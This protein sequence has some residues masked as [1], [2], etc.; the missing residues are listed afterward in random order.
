MVSI[1]DYVLSGG[2]LAALVIIDAVMRLLPGVLGNA[3]SVRHES[4]TGG[5]LEH[6]H[7]TRPA[8]WRGMAVPPVLLSGHHA[9]IAGWRRR[10]SVE[11]TARLRPDLLACAELSDA[12]RDELL[13]RVTE[14]SNHSEETE[15]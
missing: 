10:A 13:A 14:L 15:G 1:G 7:Y 9:N 6:P 8:E 5:L 4:F 2:E 11:R 12:E 3:D